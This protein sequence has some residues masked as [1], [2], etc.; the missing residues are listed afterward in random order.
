MIRILQAVTSVRV[1]DGASV[2]S[3]DLPLA[4]ERH[5][6]WPFLPGSSVKGA[7]RSRALVRGAPADDILYAFGSEPGKPEDTALTM[8]AVR[9]TQATLLALPVRSL[10]ST[11]V[12]LTCP[13]ALARLGRAVQASQALPMPTQ[14]EAMVARQEL[15]GARAVG[16][17]A[18][19]PVYV[20]D[21]DLQGVVSSEVTP[22]VDLLQ[23]HT[24]G[25]APLDRLVVVH[26][27]VFAHATRAWTEVRTRNA[28]GDDGIVEDGKLFAVETLPAETLWW[29]SV[30]GDDRGLLPASGEVFVIGGHQSV[31]N[32]RVAWF[33]GET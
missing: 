24:E 29:L 4:R 31:G 7:L 2:S 11:F 27:D 17:D 20:E 23:A 3:V 33:G 16:S 19:G 5:T 14:A 1:G 9:V 21:L 6:R 18:L 30:E 22:W 12:L 8:G 28:V 26:D 15:T 25:E 10:H 13:T 32:G